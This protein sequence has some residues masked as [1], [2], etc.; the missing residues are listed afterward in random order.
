MARKFDL[1][2][3]T[4]KY[5]DGECKLHELAC[6]QCDFYDLCKENTKQLCKYKCTCDKWLESFKQVVIA[7]TEK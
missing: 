1:N 2:N 4:K 7:L 3:I 6:F 5:T